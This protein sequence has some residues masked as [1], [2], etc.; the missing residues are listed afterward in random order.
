LGTAAHFCEERLPTTPG[1]NGLNFRAFALGEFVIDENADGL[2]DTLFRT[3]TISAR[4]AKAKWPEGLSKETQDAAEKEPE[5]LVEFLHCIYPRPGGK[6]PTVLD[7]GTMSAVPASALPYASC[8]LEKGRKTLVEEGGYHECPFGCI[9]WSMTPG[10]VYGTGVGAGALG[11]IKTLNKSVEMFLL[12]WA[13]AIQP[14]TMSTVNNIIGVL[15]WIPG[16]NTIVRRLDAFK[17]F[18]TNARFDVTMAG[19]ENLRKSVR[20]MFFSAQLE[21]KQSPEMSATEVAARMQL[22]SQFLGP[23]SGRFMSDWLTKILIRIFGI[24]SRIPQKHAVFPP[25]PPRLAQYIRSEGADFEI[26]FLTPMARQQRNPELAAIERYTQ[27]LIAVQQL[28]PASLDTI[29]FDKALAVSADIM[30]VPPSV[31]RG[32]EEL[33]QVRAAKMQAQQEAAQLA[34]MQAIAQAAGQAAPMV[35]ALQPTTGGA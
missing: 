24:M 13:L 32:A 8:Y 10:E 19:I 33:A 14:P 12:Q 18:I 20:D 9:R 29:D 6:T 27:M 3:F 31:L 21:L 34:Q 28:H 1:F 23:A 17:E 16:G 4:A 15:K 25:T 2:V 7:D 35:K 30:G 5:A 11:D 22:M 26:K